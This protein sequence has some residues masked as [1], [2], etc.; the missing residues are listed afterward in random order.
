M[1]FVNYYR[2]L[3][4]KLSKAVYSLNQLLKK[5]KK[6]KWKQREEESFRQII[7]SISKESRIRF[8]DSKISFI[9]ETN[10]LDYTTEAIL[11]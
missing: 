5:E 10:A 4:F 7:K 11:L 3:I 6:W 2:K 8:Y 9:I 1:D